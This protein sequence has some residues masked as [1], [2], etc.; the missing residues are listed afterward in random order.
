MRAVGDAFQLAVI[1]P[2]G[3]AKVKALPKGH[4]D[5]GETA[6]QAATREVQEE[7]GLTVTPIEKV[8]DVKYVYRFR[9]KTIF[10]VVSFFLFKPVAGEI[11]QLTPQ[12]RVEVDRAEWIP[13][14]SAEHTLSYP[15]ERDMV[16][17]AMAILSRG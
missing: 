11:D 16:S 13:A 2:R 12:M 9:G 8:G 3:K 14:A 10:K 1:T 5:K 4:I 6:L 7:T 17:K 15:G